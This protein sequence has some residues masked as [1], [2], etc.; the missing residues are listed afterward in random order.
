MTATM[1]S[2]LPSSL[3]APATEPTRARIDAAVDTLTAQLERTVIERDQA[4]GLPR[5]ER[6][7]IR[8][9]GLLRLTVPTQ[10]GGDGQPL[11]VLLEVV[12]DVARVDPAL[13]HVFA[14][15]HLMLASVRLYASEE[16]WSAV[17]RETA[18]E[19]LFWGNALNPRDTRT[20]LR[21]DSG[22]PGR[23]SIDG[24]KSFCSGAGDSDRLIV[25]AQHP[26]TNKLVVAMVP[27]RREGIRVLGDWDAIGQRQTDS[28][29]VEL[30]DVT[31]DER[32]LL[33][34][35]GPLGSVFSSLRSCIAQAILVH[36]YL[37]IGEGA[38]LAAKQALLR[39]ASSPAQTDEG[40][41]HVRAGELLVE[42]EGASVLAER[43]RR[44]L[45]AAWQRG[46]AL[47]EA[48]RGEAAIHVA[49]AKVASTR[50]GLTVTTRMFEL[51]GARSAMRATA[52]DRYFRNL[53]THTL[54]DPIDEKLRELGAF[55]LAGSTPRPG[56]Y[57]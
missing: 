2:A 9:S 35:P 44:T 32:E 29:T 15:H 43:A 18:A 8:Q 36:I 42:L 12:R 14:F 28:G 50:A 22:Q 47:T 40:L 25:S 1:T 20:Q 38:F 57:A 54:H 48:E 51:L 34:T 55:A 17:Y 6:D 7:L 53:R 13:A 30:H 16:Q 52:Y 37:G 56:F 24:T 10:F 49:L 46:D 19:N 23:L 39:R 3:F 27:T 41:L 33:T 4:G 26:V 45:D 5:H 31:V 21:I 11:S